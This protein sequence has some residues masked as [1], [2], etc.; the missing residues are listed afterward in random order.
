[1]G[2]LGGGR[3]GDPQRSRLAHPLGLGHNLARHRCG[4]TLPLG[5]I[6][7]EGGRWVRA[8]KR[9][10]NGRGHLGLTDLV[11]LGGTGIL[12]VLVGIVA[13]L[14]PPNIWDAMQYHLPRVVLWIENGRVAFYPTHELKQLHMAPGAEY[15][16]LQVHALGGGD[17]LDISS[18]GAPS[19][20]ASWE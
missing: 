7:P 12:V 10:K 3:D 4:R 18:S 19:W 11:L 2:R 14:S 13:I 20:G 8:G 17:R 1:V 16:L 15:V 6:R 5:A 9:L